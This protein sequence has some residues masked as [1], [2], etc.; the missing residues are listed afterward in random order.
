VTS[1]QALD[2]ALDDAVG[3]WGKIDI[4]VANAGIG[5][6]VKAE[7]MTERQWNSVMDVNLKGVFFSAQSAARHMIH[8]QSGNII[9]ISSLSGSVANGNPQ[10]CYNASKAAVNMLVRCL[11]Y[12]WA[13]YNIRVNGIAPGYIRTDMISPS[14][15]KFPEESYS[16]MVKPAAMNRIGSPDELAGAGVFLA[17][18]AS[19]YMTGQV[20]VIDGGYTLTPLENR[21]M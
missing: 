1:R 12:E 17:S 8:R 4:M 11:A 19:S 5:I 6:G 18:D 9:A 20:I 10:A 7:D 14:L 16:L 13:K 2:E 21:L 3:R 15:Q